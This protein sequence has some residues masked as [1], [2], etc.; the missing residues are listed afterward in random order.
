MSKKQ[1]P[2][3]PQP[4]P[5]PATQPKVTVQQPA[6]G[7]QQPKTSLKLSLTLKLSLILAVITF[8]IYANTLQNG[9]VLDDSMVCSKNTIVNQGYAGIPELLKTPRL[10]GFGYLKNENYRPL[11]LVMFAIEI[12]TFGLNP[13]Y[14][15]LF[16]IL[17]FAC[18]VVLLFLFL[19]K[20]FER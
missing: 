1:Q 4:A 9:Y 14:G 19:Y 18:C 11:S 10:K 20:L 17:F 2:R 8:I 13:M 16:N 7:T 5:A 6:A 12:G 15:H 3:K